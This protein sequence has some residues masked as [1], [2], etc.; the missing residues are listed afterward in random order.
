VSWRAKS[1]ARWNLAR[2]GAKPSA[3]G[4]P[5]RACSREV[6]LIAHG[7]RAE[8]RTRLRGVEVMTALGLAPV[9]AA[10]VA[11]VSRV[12]L[13]RWRARRRRGFP[14]VHRRPGIASDGVGRDADDAQLVRRIQSEADH[15]WV[16]DSSSS[17]AVTTGGHLPESTANT[18]DAGVASGP[19][20]PGEGD[21]PAMRAILL[22]TVSLKRT[23]TWPTHA[24][25]LKTPVSGVRLALGRCSLVW[26]SARVRQAAL[27]GRAP[28]PLLHVP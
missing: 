28:W 13:S 17:P 11:G 2:E 3:N 1:K 9:L 26:R 7:A 16:R 12:A 6:F 10:A 27:P 4:R 21:A 14:L 18:P 25:G 8:A 24:Q 22:A 5:H 15:S 23:R 19:S 20:G